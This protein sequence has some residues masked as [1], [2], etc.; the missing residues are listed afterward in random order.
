[1]S[2]RIDEV[3]KYYKPIKKLD[4]LNNILF[5]VSVI[6]SLA[7]FYEN[8]ITLLGWH[9]WSS[10]LFIV[11]VAVHLLLSLFLEFYLMPQADGKRRKQLLSNSFNI[12]LVPEKT[13]GYYNNPLAPSIARLGA[14]LLEN[15]LFTK[16]ISSRMASKERIK[17]LIYFVIWIFALSWRSTELG[18]AVII[19]QTLFSSEILAL[20]I[21]IELLRHQSEILYNELYN[22]FLHKIN[23]ENPDGVAAAIDSLVAYE[24]AKAMTRVRLSSSI[25]NE[26]NPTLSVEWNKFE[27][28]SKFLSPPQADGVLRNF[29]PTGTDFS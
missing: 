18:L 7:V 11:V 6:L 2:E 8:R 3:E 17:V 28:S 16:S 10:V 4:E 25:F 1:M 12:P 27:K 26:L 21:R 9:E 22:S 20:W 24:T 13:Q 23:F 15:L 5:W 19:T 14:N 29:A